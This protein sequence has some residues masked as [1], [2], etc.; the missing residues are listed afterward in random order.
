MLHSLILPAAPGSTDRDGPRGAASEQ[1]PHTAK[2]GWLAARASAVSVGPA[3]ARHGA[4]LLA[5]N[6]LSAVG[7]GLAAGD[8]DAAHWTAAAVVAAASLAVGKAFGVSLR[9][10]RDAPAAAAFE[11]RAL[12]LDA[13]AALD[14]AHP[15]GSRGTP[16]R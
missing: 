16:Q 4:G 14:D 7:Y 11:V 1:A 12:L 5:V 10:R 9:A 15:Q 3:A 8:F 2:R 13:R 6:F